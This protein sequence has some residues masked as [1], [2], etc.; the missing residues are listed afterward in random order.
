M[1]GEEKNKSMLLPSQNMLLLSSEGTKIQLQLDSNMF[2]NFSE[3]FN[4]TSIKHQIAIT[5]ERSK[6]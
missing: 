1:L 5:D 4:V 3:N 2:T 6:K